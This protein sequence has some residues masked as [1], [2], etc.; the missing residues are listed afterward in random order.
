M[1]KHLCICSVP[2]CRNNRR[3]ALIW[4]NNTT[5]NFGTD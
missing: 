3:A 5:E 2:I 1:V 4:I